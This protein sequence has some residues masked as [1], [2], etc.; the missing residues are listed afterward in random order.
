MTQE[1]DNEIRETLES[2]FEALPQPSVLKTPN[3]S[4]S[5]YQAVYRPNSYNQITCYGLSANEAVI[6]LAET[7]AAVKEA[8]Q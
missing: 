6:K 2:V 5:K 3:A 7:L 4:T 1:Q 8:N